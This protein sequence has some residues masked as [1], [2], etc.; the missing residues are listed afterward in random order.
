MVHLYA[1][2]LEKE[3]RAFEK[4]ALI[5]SQ[6]RLC[7]TRLVLHANASMSFSN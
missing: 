7:E 4:C 1:K 2:G 3:S 5:R 6:V